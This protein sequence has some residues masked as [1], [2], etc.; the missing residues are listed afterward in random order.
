MVRR[1]PTVPL[2][3]GHPDLPDELLV[4]V[5]TDDDD[6]LGEPS[7]RVRDRQVPERLERLGWSV[8][9]VWSAAAFLDPQAEADAIAQAVVEAYQVK[10]RDRPRAVPAAVPDRVQDDAESVPVEPRAG[11]AVPVRPA[12]SPGKPIS[13]YSDD[14]LDDLVA[15]LR[16]QDDARD[17]EQLAAAVRAEL[18]LKRRGSRI[19][20]VVGAAVR[21]ATGA[22]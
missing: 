15:W 10:V 20:A 9:Q 21:R 19:D 22:S 18:G 13:A 16:A 14:E 17:E 12:L 4:A 8:V 5:L 1:A 3:V 11:G 6:Y 7:V 2:A